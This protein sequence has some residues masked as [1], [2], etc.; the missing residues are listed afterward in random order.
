MPP[1]N[2]DG[3]MAYRSSHLEVAQHETSPCSSTHTVLRIAEHHK[4]T[5][6]LR[7]PHP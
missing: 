7:H 1:N 2:S 4:P 3:I 5:E 6:H